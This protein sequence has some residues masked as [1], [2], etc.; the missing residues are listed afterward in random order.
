MTKNYVTITLTFSQVYYAQIRGFIQD[1][2]CEKSA[3]LTWLLPTLHSGFD[4]QTRLHPGFHPQ[5]FVSG[6]EEDLPRAMDYLHFVCR[7]PA[8]EEIGRNVLSV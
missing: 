2:F 8:G 1:Q 5:A 6:P 4:G 3:V 7:A